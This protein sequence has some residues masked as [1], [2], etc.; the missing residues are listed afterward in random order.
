MREFP[1]EWYEQSAVQLT[2]P[3][4]STDWKD[5]LE[6]VIP[7]FKSI[8]DE[9]SEDQK[10]L[11]VTQDVS[12]VK[13]MFD[14]NANIVVVESE[15]ND[16][17][18]RD[19]GGIS[20]FEDG[21]P[22]LLDFG[23]NAWGNKFEFNK[24]NDITQRKFKAGVFKPEVEYSDNLDFILEGG[25]VES[26]GK[27]TL[28]TTSE[29]LLS[30]ERNPQFSKVE[31]ENELKKRLGANRILW[32]DNGYLAGDDTDSHIDTLA[33]L[34]SEDT[35]AYVACEDE[36]DEHYISLKAMETELM[37]F[38]QDNGEPYRLVKLPMADAVYDEEDRLPATY[39]NFLIIN[40][41]VLVPFYNSKKDEEVKKIMAEL[42]P[43]REIVGINC[44]P[45]IKQHGSLH[46]ITMQYP[47]EFVK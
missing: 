18:A 6:E 14:G 13:Q 27:G 11:I 33:R 28:L 32:L 16:T 45:L 38:R 23:F 10:V 12:A 21:K 4:A 15:I 36:N 9:I 20:V 5:I 47:K 37:D 41:K 24:D 46:C 39:A 35:I 42:Y 17:W 8:A 19:H 22:V 2:W 7:V 43:D 31:I 3:D 26:D 29:C 25:S 30:P 40:K 44:L 1:A 34:I